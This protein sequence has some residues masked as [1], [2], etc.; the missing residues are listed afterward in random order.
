ME[1]SELKRWVRDIN[2]SLLISEYSVDIN[3]SNR[4][5]SMQWLKPNRKLINYVTEIGAVLTGSRAIR[6]YSVN[7]KVLL[8][9]PTK[10]WDFV[11]T[12]DMAFKICDHFG[13]KYD[14]S[15]FI[16]VKR[17]RWMYESAYSGTYR[18]GPVDVQ[19][20]IKDDLPDYNEINGIRIANLGY[21]LN[22]KIELLNDNKKHKDDILQIITKFNSIS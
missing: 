7:N 2:M 12:Q 15:K 22:Q 3:V 10:D 20:I 18:F 13:I 1:N 4:K 6:C 5:D 21:C 16:S 8:E 19:L 11:I 17:Q 14:L 9:R